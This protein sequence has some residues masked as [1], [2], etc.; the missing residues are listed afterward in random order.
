LK[1][2]Q[3]QIASPLKLKRTAS[4]VSNASSKKGKKAYLTPV[5]AQNLRPKGLNQNIFKG[6]KPIIQNKMPMFKFVTKPAEPAKEQPKKPMPEPKSIKGNNSRAFVI[7]KSTKALTVPQNVCFQ[8]T[9]RIG[10]K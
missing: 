7:F 4:V 2:N 9:K 3:S 10:R 5:L 1:K 6:I 8:T